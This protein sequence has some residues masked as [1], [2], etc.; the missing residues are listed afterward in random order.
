MEWSTG[1]GDCFDDLPVC[2]YT[3]FCP[4]CANASA[5]TNYDGSSWCFNCM[6]VGPVM[7]R[8]IVR[9]GAFN[10][11]GNCAGDICS[12][13]CCCPLS[14]CQILREMKLRG[15]VAE[16]KEEAERKR[17]AAS[18]QQWS[19]GL[20]DFNVDW[21]LCAFGCCCPCCAL[22]QARTEYDTSNWCFNCIV[23]NLGFPDVCV[24]RNIIREGTYNIQGSC[25]EDIYMSTCCGP[26]VICQLLRENKVKGGCPVNKDI[27]QGAPRQEAW[28][29]SHAIVGDN[30]GLPGGRGGGRGR[31]GGGH[32]AGRR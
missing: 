1:M 2:L 26:C 32:G 25:C 29:A 20:F 24:A 13:C 23:L 12:G 9:E 10:I 8:S 27:V 3:C 28:G 4:P 11:G 22:A 5:R 18:M 15:T 21:G 16:A 30:H 31:G 6:F 14:T 19:T 17:G 7:V